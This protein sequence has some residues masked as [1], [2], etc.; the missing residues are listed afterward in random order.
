MTFLPNRETSAVGH[1]IRLTPLAPAVA[2]PPELRVRFNIVWSTLAIQ[3][4]RALALDTW[5]H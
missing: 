1:L 3:Q 4:S 5:R 2:R